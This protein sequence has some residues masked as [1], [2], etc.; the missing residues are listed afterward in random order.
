[1]IDL[2]HERFTSEKTLRSCRGDHVVPFPSMRR[3]LVNDRD[4]F[5]TTKIFD[6]HSGIPPYEGHF[7]NL[8]IAT[9]VE[10]K[11]PIR[12]VFKGDNS[13]SPSVYR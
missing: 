10:C 4:L 5:R 2:L 1:M 9:Q 3:E 8:G 7:I 6:M 13:T 11:I 12:C